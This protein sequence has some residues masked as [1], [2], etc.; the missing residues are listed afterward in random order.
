MKIYF[1]GGGTGGH[2]FPGIAVIQEW[3]STMKQQPSDILWIGS[4]KAMEYKIASSYG[5]K[6]K[7]IACGKLRRYFSLK[8]LV[9]VFKIIGG[10]FDCLFFFIIKRPDVIFSKGGYVSVPPCLAAWL[11]R[12]PFITHE[13]D[14]TPGLATKINSHFASLVLTAYDVTCKMLPARVN[15]KSVG[16]PVR[17]QIME[18]KVATGRKLVK[19]PKGKKILLV[20]GGSLGAQFINETISKAATFLKDECYI[21]QQ[22]G[23]GNYKPCENEHRITFPFFKE[24]FPHILASADIILSRAGAGTL[25]ESAVTKKPSILIPLGLGS[26]R[27]DQ[28][29]NAKYFS[30]RGGAI[31]IPQEECT[32]KLLATKIKELLNNEVTKKNMK[33]A[34]SEIANPECASLIVDEII[35]FLENRELGKK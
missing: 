1:T 11:L 17:R 22:M 29:E 30:N 15:A 31:V 3:C 33:K 8:N 6:F 2:V 21:V 32:P 10:F 18:G 5:L 13:S 12:I 35:T 28:L 9:D 14:I 26:S 20:L 24:E 23:E 16:N 25:W 4:K 7:S 19:A 27:G 34:L